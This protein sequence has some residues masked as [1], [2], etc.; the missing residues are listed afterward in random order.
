MRNI[1]LVFAVSVHEASNCLLWS[2][3]SEN[4]SLK[5]NSEVFTWISSGVV[6]GSKSQVLGAQT[7]INSYLDF[8]FL[9]PSP[10][11]SV[12]DI[13][14]GT[15]RLAM[16][17]NYTGLE[18]SICWFMQIQTQLRNVFKQQKLLTAVQSKMSADQINRRWTSGNLH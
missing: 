5:T 14:L 2:K 6:M 9:S 15:I 18:F 13:E 17:N 1:C 7:R 12:S 16:L 4:W 3:D 8:H 10:S 11:V